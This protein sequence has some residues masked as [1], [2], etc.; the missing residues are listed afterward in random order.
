MI[1]HNL[2]TP[3]QPSPQVFAPLPPLS[4]DP[5]QAVQSPGAAEPTPLPNSRPRLR[6]SAGLETTGVAPQTTSTIERASASDRP[7]ISRATLE[8]WKE[9]AGNTHNKTTLVAALR[10]VQRAVELDPSADVAALLETTKFSVH[11]QSTFGRA[12]V[13]EPGEQLSIGWY[14]R[15]HQQHVPQNLEQL[16]NF[17]D[18]TANPLPQPPSAGNYWGALAA[19]GSDQ[20]TQLQDRV[21]TEAA[22][23]SSGNS[24][25]KTFHDTHGASVA[26]LTAAE[27]LDAMISSPALQALGQKLKDSL[28][29]ASASGSPEQLAMAALVLELDPQA[30]SQ[31]GVVAGYDLYQPANQGVHPAVVVERLAQH[32]VSQGKVPAEM[33][34]AAARLLLAGAAPA[35]LVADVPANL[36]LG[37]ATWARLQAA[38]ET[39]EFWAPGIAAHTG[40]QAFMTRADYAPISDNEAIVHGVAQAHALIEWGV[41]QGRIAR[42]DDNAYTQAEVAGLR[43]AFNDE[44]HGLKKAQQQLG[45]TMP[46][47]RNIALQELKQAYGAT[48]SFEVRNIRISNIDASESDEHSLLEIYMAGK[49]DRIPKGE[50]YDFQLGN[51]VA[52]VKPLPDIDQQFNSQFDE[53]F[54][55]LKQGVATVV[56]HQL[57]QLPLEDRQTIASGKVEFFS[58]RKAGEAQ[59]NGE[60]SSAEEQAAKARHGLLMRVESKIDPYGSDRDRKNIRHVY[61]EVFPLQG[62]IRRRDDLPRYLP[63][64]A[65]RRADP[66]NFETRQAQGVGLWVDYEAYERGTQPKHGTYSH[67]LLTEPV[68]GP[69][70]PEVGQVGNANA[71]VHANPRF[72]TIA[73]AISDYLLHDRDGMKA[74]AKGMTE[75]EKEEAGIQAGFDFVTGLIPFK[76]AIENAAKG[77]TGEAVKEFA[78]DIFGFVVPFAKGA[79][80]AARQLGTGV[81]KLGTRAFN[82]SSAVTKG[83]FNGLNPGYGLGDLTLGLAK[84]N[85][86]LLQKSYKELKAL[87]PAHHVN[88]AMLGKASGT[89]DNGLVE[90]FAADKARLAGLTPDSHGVYR[91]AD[92]SLY[93]RSVNESGEAT[94]FRVREVTH[95]QG[96]VQARVIDPRT[97]RQTE[98]LLHKTGPDQWSRLGLQG[99]VSN[100]RPH[101]QNNQ[102]LGEPSVPKRPKVIESFPGEKAA[103]TE[104]VKGVNRFYHYTGPKNHAGITGSRTLDPSSSTLD[105]KPLGRGQGRH[106]FTDLAPGDKTMKETSQA[107][108]GIRKYGNAQDKMSHYYEVNTSGLTMIPT[109]K[110]HIFYVNTPFAIPLKYLN[111]NGDVV[112]RVISHGAVSAFKPD[113]KKAPA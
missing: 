16:S 65:P 54:R 47:R 101:A 82:A 55:N 52:S 37:S 66:E 60:E 42:K 88:P 108:F 105:G 7:Q 90:R 34:P 41:A 18:V 46:T 78:L 76:R 80:V 17:I 45:A 2:G 5:A 40:F 59:A 15:E 95:T 24:L 23:A 110:P 86:T 109:D 67:G 69:Y 12:H 64:P 58:L 83:I 25:F 71:A 100:K 75:V 39:A 104:P 4:V 30:G 9:R 48:D 22:G 8:E 113:P 84:G 103:L 98:Y 19:P 57:S 53:Y 51:R 94:V 97:N 87:L 89:A 6:R 35:F 50:R 73:N 62:V 13:L 93:I 70:L 56:T 112:D 3:H 32:L 44:L 106:Y 28:P 36:V 33:A 27:T 102:A 74:A 79:G 21:A 1:T 10:E 72:N 68:K 77:N 14:L 20:R 63:N 91:A 43:D 99:G 111:S 85:K 26:G 49:M 11:S 31:R 96:A 61:Y 81:G 107:I 92:D 38:V 29:G